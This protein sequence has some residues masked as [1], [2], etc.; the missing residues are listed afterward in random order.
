MQYA[1]SHK[2]STTRIL[3]EQV[4]PL[5][6]ELRMTRIAG[7]RPEVDSSYVTREEA[8]DLYAPALI[9]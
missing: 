7:L 1:I 2:T 6:R 8:S 9:K 3:Q 5:F 4:A